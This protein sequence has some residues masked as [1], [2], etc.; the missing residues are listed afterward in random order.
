LR[1]CLA[2]HRSSRHRFSAILPLSASADLMLSSAAPTSDKIDFKKILQWQRQAISIS[3]EFDVFFKKRCIG[4]WASYLFVT[5]PIH[6]FTDVNVAKAHDYF[7]INYYYFIAVMLISKYYLATFMRP[8]YLVSQRKILER[9][10]NDGHEENID[11]GRGGH[12]NGR[13]WR[14]QWRWHGSA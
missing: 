10:W 2:R 13:L 8:N 9:H 4:W 6:C 14:W 3:V 12:R 1:S 5:D 11:I 7:S